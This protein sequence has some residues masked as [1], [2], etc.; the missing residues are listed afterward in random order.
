MENFS[1]NNAK[2]WKPHLQ[3]LQH[4]MTTTQKKKANDFVHKHICNLLNWLTKQKTT[5]PT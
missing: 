4:R 3:H 1:E 2:T 5:L